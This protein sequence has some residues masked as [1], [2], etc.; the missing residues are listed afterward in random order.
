MT[1]RYKEGTLALA[2]YAALTWAGVSLLAW[3][4]SGGFESTFGLAGFRRVLPGLD[5]GPG[6]EAALL[7]RAK[8]LSLRLEFLREGRVVGRY[9]LSPDEP[10]EG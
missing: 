3:F 8:G 2:T 5:G 10:L 7:A 4:P 9:S 1:K 6:G